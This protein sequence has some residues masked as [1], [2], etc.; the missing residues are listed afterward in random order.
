[1]KKK[2]LGALILILALI[3]PNISFGKIKLTALFTDNMI[4][5]QQTK[6]L[7]PWL[8]RAVSDKTSTID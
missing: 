7:R 3:T 6:I 2:A 5:Q 1:M 8:S 4:L